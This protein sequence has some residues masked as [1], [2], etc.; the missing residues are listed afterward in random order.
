MWE[1]CHVLRSLCGEYVKH[2]FV[3]HPCLV[4]SCQRCIW[5]LIIVIYKRLSGNVFSC[6]LIMWSQCMTHKFGQH[7]KKAAMSQWHTIYCDDAYFLDTVM[8]TCLSIPAPWLQKFLFSRQFYQTSVAAPW[9]HNSA[10]WWRMCGEGIPVL[11][12]LIQWYG[13]VLR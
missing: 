13:H 8:R 6:E 12:I 2:V 1:T 7:G 11:S 5:L 4:N 3:Q 9:F 10:D